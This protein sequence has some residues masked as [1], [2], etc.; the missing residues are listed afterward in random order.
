ME[1]R[2]TISGTLIG[3]TGTETP[4][5]KLQEGKD[6]G[7]FFIG[8]PDLRLQLIRSSECDFSSFEFNVFIRFDINILEY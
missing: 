7:C 1:P 5:Y 2:L 8:F 3:Y 4:E 6:C